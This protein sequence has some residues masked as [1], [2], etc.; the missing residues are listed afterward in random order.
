MPL[1][2]FGDIQFK[3]G[4]VSGPLQPLVESKYKTST[5]R[6]PLDIGNADK[7]HYMLLYIKKQEASK[8]SGESTPTGFT[9]AAAAALKNPISGAVTDVLNSARGAVKTNLGGELANGV[10]NAFNQV[11][12]ATGGVIGN[13]TSSVGSA[14]NS[15]KGTVGNFN[16]PFG[17]PNIF[18]VSGAVA[19]EINRTNIKSLVVG[20]GDLARGIRKVTR[21]GQV[22]ALYM[23]DTLQFDFTQNYENLSLSGA[24][25][26]AAGAAMQKLQEGGGPNSAVGSAVKA[27]LIAK[28][29]D[30]AKEKVGD[31]G[32]LGGFLALGAVVNPLLEVIYQAPQFRTFQYDFIFY[33]RDEREAVE[34]QKIITSLQYH[35]APEFKEGSAGSLL[36]PPSEFDIEFYYAGKKNE[37]IPQTGNCV[38]KSIQVNYAP[39][40]F[41]AYEVPG[42]NAT[43]GGTGM[44]VAIQMSLQ[45]QE[46][47]YLTK[48]T[49][50]DPSA[51]SVNPAEAGTPSGILEGT[52]APGNS[53]IGA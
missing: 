6:Y 47:S 45:F 7:G 8:A 28:A 22:I 35:Q 31:L 9:D 36:I 12:N 52:N 18:N 26:A 51:V 4:S 48:N 5:L 44:P 46:T 41:S 14:F 25:G 15:F 37:N 49:P 21:T 20:S 11:N 2:G 17:Q 33:P 40:G 27:G 3:K 43:L 32:S 10:Q 34:V 1:F 29:R 19:Q 30:Y 13:L 39:N 38:L 50:G 42:Q 23:P 24:A 16:N 53:P